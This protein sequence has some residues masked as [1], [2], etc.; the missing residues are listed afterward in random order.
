MAAK[1][2]IELELTEKFAY[3]NNRGKLNKDRPT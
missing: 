1:S 3:I 2:E